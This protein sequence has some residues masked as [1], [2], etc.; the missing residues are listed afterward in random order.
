MPEPGL[1]TATGPTERAF[2]IDLAKVLAANL[3]VWH[4]LAFYGPMADRAAERWPALIDWLAQYGREAVPVFLVVGG[5]LAARGL[6][7]DGRLMRGPSMFSRL[8]D[9]YLRLS[10]PFAVIVVLAVLANLLAARWMQHD[11]ISEVLGPHQAIAHV[12]LV[13]DLVGIP[14]LTAGA[15]YVAIDFQ[16]YALL[17]VLL[18]L[19]RGSEQRVRSR[20][21]HGPWMVALLGAASLLYFNRI[22][23]L[24]II[25]LY[26][27]GAYA[28]GA[29]VAWWAPTARRRP[30]LVLMAAL[31]SLALWIEWRDRLAVALVVAIWLAVLVSVRPAA[32]ASAAWSF[33]H[34]WSERSYA[35]FLV[36]FPVCLLVN[37]AFTRWASSDAAVQAVGLVSAWLASLWAARMFHLRVEQPLSR[38]IRAWRQGRAKPAQ[39]GAEEMGSGSAR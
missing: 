4:H 32:G 14:A 19:A 35:L 12:L 3:I 16:L 24:D 5:Y 27:F 23:E 10:A 37:A 6:A 21:R 8:T 1:A 9:R 2:G 31:A 34:R 11:S 33:V 36:H 29:L 18:T 22:T 25:G 15:W 30:W 39:A 28:L 38:S 13:H 20:R 17:L 26:F 7:P